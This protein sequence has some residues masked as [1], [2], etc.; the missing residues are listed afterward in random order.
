MWSSVNTWTLNWSSMS[1][2]RRTWPSRR[3]RVSHLCARVASTSDPAFGDIRWDDCSALMWEQVIT[4]WW[5]YDLNTA[6]L[7]NSGPYDQPLFT[8]LTDEM[9]E[10]IESI[11]W[12]QLMLVWH[13]LTRPFSRGFD[14]PQSSLSSSYGY[15]GVNVDC[16]S[17]MKTVKKPSEIK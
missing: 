12:S 2:G 11:G 1:L 16:T 7:R 17:G 6:W 14:K 5:Q 8:G 15:L 3:A 13:C 9:G 10:V 4:I